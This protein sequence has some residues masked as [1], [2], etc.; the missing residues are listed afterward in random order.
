MDYKMTIAGLER[1]LPLCKVSDDLYI[2][3]FIMFND[4]EITEASARELLKKAPEFDVL[5]TAETKGIPLC[6]EMARQ[7]GKPYIVARKGPK[8]YMRDV[9]KVP[10][11]S[12]TTDHPQILCL[13]RDERAVLEGKRIL[14]VDDVISTGD[15][16]AAIETLLDSLGG[17]IVG[18]MTVLAEGAAADRDDIIFLEYLPVFT[19]EGEPIP[20]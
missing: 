5:V 8:L 17:N 7:S 15:S 1:H 4:V 2:A 10:V 20:R 12:I 11:N 18:K 9:V 13:G 14:V 6:Y 19:P 16:I 3:G